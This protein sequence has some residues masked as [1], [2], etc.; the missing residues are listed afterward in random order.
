MNGLS[1]FV[2]AE[3]QLRFAFPRPRRFERDQFVV[4]SCNRAATEAVDSWP[5]WTERRLA[6]TGPEGA[7]KTHLARAWAARTGAFVVNDDSADIAALPPGPVL[8]EDADR[9]RADTLLFHLINRADSGDTL[10]L[11]A[12]TLP[13]AWAADLPDLRSRLNALPIAAIGEPDDAVL[14]GV[15]IRLFREKD[16]RPDSELLCYLLR[17]IER[18]VPAA[19]AVVARLDVAADAYRRAV[20][21]TLAREILEDEDNT[22][23]L[24]E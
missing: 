2:G 8:F 16:I 9:R 5:N 3:T 7:G 4:S 15:L 18:S 14:E 13:R 20:N 17:R 12:R 22:L 11:T 24:F 1:Q 21:R 10:L 6:L 23:D 19:E